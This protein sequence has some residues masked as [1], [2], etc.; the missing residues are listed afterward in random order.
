MRHPQW[1]GFLFQT[2]L[3][4]VGAL[5]F[6]RAA[7]GWVAALVACATVV[8][9]QPVTGS[10][11][12]LRTWSEARLKLP[13]GQLQAEEPS[14]LAARGEYAGLGTVLS[15]E[16]D[17]LAQFIS[18]HYRVAVEQ[19]RVF[20][21]AAYR[22]AR[23]YRLEPSLILAVMAVESSFDPGAVSPA[24]AHGL[25]QVL[26][27]VHVDR[28]APF[29][30]AAAAFDPIANIRVGAQILREYMTRE[31]TVEGALRVYVGA[32]NA[33]SDQGYGAKV[34]AERNRLSAVAAGRPVPVWLTASRTMTPTRAGAGSTGP[35][36][37][38]PMDAVSLPGPSRHPDLVPSSSAMP[39]SMAF[40]HADH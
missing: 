4:L 25:M 7:S 10:Q 8:L 22:A 5:R 6:T 40:H 35:A 21:D 13:E 2:F 32:A 12:A 30:G 9:W 16:Q 17:N 31:G 38:G 36:S 15:R 19:T 28:F 23:E 3:R 11:F 26:T 24:G 34:L 39:A 18:M 37:D 33:P 27:R 14:G 20:V 29:G 1:I